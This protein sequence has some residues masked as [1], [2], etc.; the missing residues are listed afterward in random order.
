MEKER[1]EEVHYFKKGNA[2]AEVKSE[3][4]CRRK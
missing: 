3:P 2:N 4:R 1:L